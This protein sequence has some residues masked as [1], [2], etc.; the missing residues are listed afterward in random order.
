M[1]DFHSFLRALKRI[2]YDGP[3]TFESS[4]AVIDETLSRSLAVWRNLWDDSD[5]LG[6]HAHTLIRNTM[7]TVETLQ[8]A[9]TAA[10]HGALRLTEGKQMPMS[11]LIRPTSPPSEAYRRVRRPAGDDRS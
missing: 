3:I 11:V 7:C 9:L 5:D 1:V 4:T 6:A 8:T 2:G 10:G